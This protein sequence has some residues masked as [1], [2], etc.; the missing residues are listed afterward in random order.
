VS[1]NPFPHLALIP[2]PIRLLSAGVLINRAGGFVSLFLPLI[3]ALRGISA[4]KIA[5]ALAACGIFV[6][7]G[8]W[9]G[10]TF[11]S[12]LGGKRVIIASMAGSALLTAALAPASAYP[13][14]VAVVCLIALFNRAYVPAA[15]MMVGRFAPPD[16]RLPMFS[17]FQLCLNVGVAIGSAAAGFLLTHSLT[18]LLLIDAATSAG[19]A[20]VALRLPAADGP[21]APITPGPAPAT[22][23]LRHDHR[24]LVFCAAT[25][26]VAMAYTQTRGPLPLAFRAHHYNLELMGYLFSANAV[27]I[28]AFQLPLSLVT[29]RWPTRVPLAV[30]GFLMGGAY[31]LFAVGFSLP[32]LIGNVALWTA[33]E[34]VYAPAAPSAAVMMSRPGLRGTYQGAL[35]VA[36]SAG[37]ALGPPL[38][39]LAFAAGG[40][41][42]WWATGALGAVAACVFWVAMRPRVQTAAAYATEPAR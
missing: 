9:L 32:L 19:F 39:V 13:V 29:R 10:G 27:A 25:V 30:G 11:A 18:A 36:R 40:S 15:S 16:Q 2:G 35:D 17:F 37:Q 38:G 1:P 23:K 12:R 20:L 8:A 42:V 7:A 34:I 14:T 31:L 41:L 33:G 6:I 3:L 22:G 28:I 21:V 5:V 26:L 4:T 24:Y